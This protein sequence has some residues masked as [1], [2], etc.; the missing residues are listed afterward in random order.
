LFAVVIAI[1][2]CGTV[3]AAGTFIMLQ[4][5]GAQTAKISQNGEYLSACIHG[6]DGARWTR[7][8]GIEQLVPDSVSGDGSTIG[9]WLC[10]NAGIRSFVVLLNLPDLIFEDGFDTAP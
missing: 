2:G 3:H 6:T 4:A 10:T 7:S 8:T 1:A 9:G 5:Q